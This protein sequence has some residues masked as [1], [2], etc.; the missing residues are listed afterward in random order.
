M[1]INKKTDASSSRI[2]KGKNVKRRSGKYE[3]RG[4]WRIITKFWV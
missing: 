4:I 3:D 2:F 1:P